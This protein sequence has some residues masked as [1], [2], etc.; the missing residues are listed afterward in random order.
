[1]RSLALL[2]ILITSILSHSFTL[3]AFSPTPAL[4]WNRPVSFYEFVGEPLAPAVPALSAPVTGLLVVMV[5]ATGAW[6][7]RR[8]NLLRP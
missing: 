2:L 5:T 3:P 8:R 7:T 6:L 1:M 4:S